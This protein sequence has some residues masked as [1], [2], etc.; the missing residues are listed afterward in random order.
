VV[1]TELVGLVPRKAASDSL[2][3]YTQLSRF[4]PD[5]ILETHLGPEP[6]E[7]AVTI[8]EAFVDEV[9]AASPTPGGG[10]VAAYAGGLG[11]ALAA[12]VAGL[13]I[14]K[15]RYAAVEEDMQRVRS[16]AFD[17]QRAMLDLL[18]ADIAAF[19][20]VMAAYKLPKD[21]P[22]GGGARQEAIQE[23]LRRAT[24]VPLQTMRSAVEILEIAA[25]AAEHGNTNAISDA[26]IAGRMAHAACHGASFN[27][28]IN[29][30][31][32]RDLAEGDAYRR[33]AMDLTKRAD[34]LVEEV[35]RIV[36]SR[37]AG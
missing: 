28:A 14:G 23:S 19:E 15:A 24:E 17:L 30:R 8:P 12:M 22:A 27:V 36:R 20:A 21:D 6:G 26:G 13:T 16:R 1:S 11:A 25:V 37:I 3:W 35:D 29:I 10:S 9:A 18:D 34:R 32:L 33:E 5:R 7:I 4:G 31:S 2:A